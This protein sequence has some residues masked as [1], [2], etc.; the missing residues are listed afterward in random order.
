[1]GRFLCVDRI[2]RTPTSTTLPHNMLKYLH[3][4]SNLIRNH[5]TC[6]LRGAYCRAF[7]DYVVEDSG[8]EGKGAYCRLVGVAAFME[9]C[10]ADGV[11]GIRFAWIGEER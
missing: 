8:R 5:L 9:D 4:E 10:F 1:M 11:W 3:A 6:S 2:G 7:G